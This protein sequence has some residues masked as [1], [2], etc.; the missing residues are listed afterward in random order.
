M[1]LAQAHSKEVI[2]SRVMWGSAL[3]SQCVSGSPGV[4]D[5]ALSFLDVFLLGQQLYTIQV[6]KLTNLCPSPKQSNHLSQPHFPKASGVTCPDLF[7]SLAAGSG[8]S[9]PAQ[10]S[11]SF[12]TRGNG[13]LGPCSS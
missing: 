5:T 3:G 7:C 9:Q 13:S 12:S 2:M 11:H 10:L 4:T 6:Y 8:D 1:E